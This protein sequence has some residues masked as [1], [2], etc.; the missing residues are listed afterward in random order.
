MR[1]EGKLEMDGDPPEWVRMVPRFRDDVEALMVL[2]DYDEPP[3]IP[4]RAKNPDAIYIVGDASGSGFGSC[5]WVQGGRIVDTEFGRWTEDVTNDKSSNFREGANL[6]IRLKRMVECGKVSR[7]TEVFICTDNKVAEATYFKGSAKSRELHEMIVELRKLEMDSGLIVHFLWISGKRMIEQGTDGLSRGEFA[8]GIM[9]GKSFLSFLPFNET[10]FH[11]Q[12]KLKNMVMSWLPTHFARWRCTTTEMWFDDV[13][14]DPVGRWVWAPP[15]CLAKIAV[16]ELCEA[17]HTL[18][19]SSHV[20]ICPAVMTGYWRKTLGKIA[21][22]MFTLKAGS[23]VWESSML[24]PLT[25]A[26][27]APLLSRS[28]WKAGRL[29]V[30]VEWER[31]M[32]S[33]QWDSTGA[34][35]HHMLEFWRQ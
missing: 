14:K 11:R 17:K 7:G 4:I 22:T 13:Y 2:T 20:F 29:P 10:A 25:I 6:V 1:R 12:P 24:E 35:R 5:V 21:D 27:V 28:P 19:G 23:V 31:E 34:V 33:L 30:M 15:P 32:S 26:F 16:D 9:Q 3:E 8:S 18:P